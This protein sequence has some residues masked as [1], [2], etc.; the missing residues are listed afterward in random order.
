MHGKGILHSADGKCSYAGEWEVGFKTIPV[1][2]DGKKVPCS[3]AT[4]SSAEAD[5]G[6]KDKALVFTVPSAA[7]AT[8]ENA[9]EVA[10]NVA[11]ISRGRGELVSQPCS[12]PDKVRRAIQA[13]AVGVVITNTDSADPDALF[14]MGGSGVPPDGF[15][16]PVV[17]VSYTSGLE[18]GSAR[19]C[20]F[21]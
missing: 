1:I 10:G 5:N 3:H 12:F 4:W 2:V 19:K 9:D 15:D 14:S 18:M 7:E 11:V 13:G 6:F 16:L 21:L 17:S 20:S 8:I